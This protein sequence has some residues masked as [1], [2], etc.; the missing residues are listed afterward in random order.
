MLIVI[1][2]ITIDAGLASNVII[3]CPDYSDICTELYTRFFAPTWLVGIGRYLKQVVY[4]TEMK[5]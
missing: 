3:K 2:I 4:P 5:R 1:I